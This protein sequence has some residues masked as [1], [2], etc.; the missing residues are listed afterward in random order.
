MEYLWANRDS[1][2][3]ITELDAAHQLPAKSGFVEFGPGDRSIVCVVEE[4]LDVLAIDRTGEY[5][6]LYHVLHGA[7]S[8]VESCEQVPSIHGRVRLFPRGTASSSTSLCVG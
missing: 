7:I 2:L 5:R 1:T 8:P 4:P 6:G 3:V